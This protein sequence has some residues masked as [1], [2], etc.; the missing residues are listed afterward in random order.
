MWQVQSLKCENFISF[1]EANLNINTNV[2]TLIY[3]VNNDNM[4]QRNNGTGKSSI[5][6]A[7][8]FALTGEP[9]RAVG[10]AEEIINDNADEATVYVELFN[11]YDDTVLTVRRKLNRKSPQ[12]IECHKYDYESGVEME[13]DKT[14]QPTVLDYNRFILE[15]I[16]L[17]KDD[18]YS[19]FILSNSKYKSFFDASDKAKKSMINRFSGADKIDSV[20]EALQSDRGP[21]EDRLGSAKNH[22]IAIEAKL[23]VIDSQLAD[24][25][26]KKA[27]WEAAKQERISNINHQ[28]AQKRE[29][30]REVKETI[31]KANT[32]IVTIDKVGDYIEND[33]QESNNS[34][35]E[36]YRDIASLFDDHKLEPIKDYISI[37]KEI[38]ES[39]TECAEKRDSLNRTLKGL[40]ESADKAG[41]VLD[42]QQKKLDELH[43]NFEVENKDSFA[44]II[45][46]RKDIDNV[47]KNIEKLL[48]NI[49][50][51]QSNMDLSSEKLRKLQNQIH[52]AITCPKCKHEFFVG[53]DITLEKAKE[54]FDE[55]S[56][57]LTRLQSLEDSLKSE[58]AECEKQLC[59]FEKELNDVN[60]EITKKRNNILDFRH[61]VEKCSSEFE[62]ASSEVAK[63]KRKINSLNNTIEV[64]Q[65]K[66]DGLVR[67]MISDALDVVDSACDKGESYVK[68][69]K[70]KVISLNASIESFEKAAEDAINSSQ[71]DFVASLNNSK[72]KY[73]K[74]LQSVLGEVE[75]AQKEFDK[76]I[77]QENHFVDFRSHLANK[78]VKAISGVT[79]HFLELIG[80]DLRVE[81]LGFKKLKNGKIRDKITVNLLRNGVDC[82][83]YAKFSGGE[84]ARV[85]LAS[86]LGLQRLTNN[87][88]PKGKGL[89][90]IILDEIL[91]ASDTTG[92]E[93]SCA[94]LNRLGVTSLMVTQNP[95]SDNDGHTIVVTKEN[96]YSTIT[97]Q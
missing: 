34:L 46:I 22:K 51:T 13:Q 25:D 92:I 11:D 80:S 45:E 38:D 83:S 15:E 17:S 90:L 19:N 21:V 3:G 14:S 26:N 85:N 89:D 54:Q 91:E 72:A 55:K 4:Q 86:I 71:D 35:A 73:E 8:A 87:S 76:Y 50:D 56:K 69:L 30:I 61:E 68:T 49:H 18:I 81:M 60:A 95:I 64:E 48:Q 58:K 42:E 93:S 66:L 78:K 62:M 10:K 94:A 79:N 23:E 32:R 53:G 9:L 39:I 74:E 63:T 47:S 37:S 67:K 88:A 57:E 6:E 84:R 77:V 52:G 29:E 16:G 12:T 36:M 96:G 97:E 20:I 65:G 31:A 2:C 24:A 5:I 70:D 43:A 82:G 28:I 7:I 41:K 75:E 27:E 1:K 33:L 44:D 40:Q 59:G